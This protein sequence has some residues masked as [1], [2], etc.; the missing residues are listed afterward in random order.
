[1]KIVYTQ[2][3]RYVLDE[4]QKTICHNEKKFQVV[5][6]PNKVE[7]GKPM[8]FTFMQDEQERKLITTE[9]LGVV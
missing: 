7:V 3:G 9:V 5:A 2:K 4:K 8:V 1:M 6:W